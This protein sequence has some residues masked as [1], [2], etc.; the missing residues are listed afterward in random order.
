MESKCQIKPDG[1]EKILTGIGTFLI[2][3]GTIIGGILA[4]ANKDINYLSGG[5]Y[6]GIIGGAI[7]IGGS[8]ISYMSRGG[9]LK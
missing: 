2:L 5:F 3:G 6:A 9:V 4:Y 7:S 1:L 8:Q